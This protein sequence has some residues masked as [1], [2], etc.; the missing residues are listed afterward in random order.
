GAARGRETAAAEEREREHQAQRRLGEPR[1][2][3]ASQAVSEAFAG[4]PGAAQARGAKR[5]LA[6][7]ARPPGEELGA[8]PQPGRPPARRPSRRPD[9]GSGWPAR[10]RSKGSANSTAPTP[11]EAHSE[12]AAVADTTNYSA[13]SASIGSTRVARRAGR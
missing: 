10:R 3:I 1:G 4:D 12:S 5:R 9:Q 2:P 8:A 6:E 13:R 11:L 7:R